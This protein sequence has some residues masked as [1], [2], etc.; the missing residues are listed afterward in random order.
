MR[1]PNLEYRVKRIKMTKMK[2]KFLA[3]GIECLQIYNNL[4]YLDLSSNHFSVQSTKA[5]CTLLGP[6]S[7]LKTLNISGCLKTFEQARSII[8]A[9]FEN[10]TVRIL[11]LSHS[12]MNH[13]GNEFGSILGRLMVLNKDLIHLD[14]SSCG[15]TG[16]DLV[17]ITLCL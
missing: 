4:E 6:G 1:N 9:M 2:G 16:P 12:K 3:K 14:V 15:L 17:Y 7:A 11:N 8:L 5:I 13:S 10:Q